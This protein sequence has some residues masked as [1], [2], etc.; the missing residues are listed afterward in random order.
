M[1]DSFDI[2]EINRNALLGSDT[3]ST[4]ENYGDNLWANKNYQFETKGPSFHQSTPQVERKQVLSKIDQA[5]NINDNKCAKCNKS[6]YAQE[7]IKAFGKRFHK[8]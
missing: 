4:T 7:E 3:E 5:I 1:A 6:V 2:D 8:V